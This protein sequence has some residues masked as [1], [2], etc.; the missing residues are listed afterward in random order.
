MLWAAGLHSGQYTRPVNYDAAFSPISLRSLRKFGRPFG[1]LQ[2]EALSFLCCDGI[3]V[4]QPGI[5]PRGHK[6]GSDRDR[7][8]KQQ[9]LFCSVCDFG[10]AKHGR[11]SALS[12]AFLGKCSQAWEASWAA[13]QSEVSLQ[14]WVQADWMLEASATSVWRWD[15]EPNTSQSVVQALQSRTGNDQRQPKKWQT[16]ISENQRQRPSDPEFG[17][18]RQQKEHLRIGHDI[19]VI[20]GH[21]VDNCQKGLAPEKKCKDGATP[22][23][24]WTE[25]FPSTDLRDQ[26]GLDE[27]GSSRIPQQSG[28]NRWD[29]DCHFWARNQTPVCCVDPAKWRSSSEGPETK[30]TKENNDDR[31]LRLP[32]CHLRQVHAPRRHNSLGG[33][34][35]N[36]G[37]V[38][39]I[40]QEE[41]TSSL[42]PQ[43]WWKLLLPP[44]SGQCSV[45]CGSA[46]NCQI[47]R[48]GNRTV[49]T[50]T[51]LSG[52][53]SVWFCS[54]PEAQG[55]PQGTSLC[56]PWTAEGWGQKIAQILPRWV[57][58]AS[59]CR[60]G[61]KVEEVHCDG[62]W[63]LRRDTC[64]STP[65]GLGRLIGQFT[66]GMNRHL[67]HLRKITPK[68]FAK[69]LCDGPFHVGFIA[70]L[71]S[72]VGMLFD[73]YDGMLLFCWH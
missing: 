45:P 68:P 6:I 18:S 8:A 49:G 33:L 61:H 31:V 60:H 48:V 67:F 34:L 54:F 35:W 27:T 55:R 56:Q 21:C 52:F 42:D 53:G 72:I 46:N 12:L 26:P 5:D 25:G 40:S 38:Q 69:C 39:G 24:R 32:G 29:M 36:I 19:R 43:S 70:I 3:S 57:L 59:L 4:T 20:Q 22:P 65:W 37:K 58:W 73:F 51:V 15:N 7:S 66:R 1:T 64:C 28:H 9:C 62:R 30:G 16:T 63:L 10:W 71:N 47:Q 14:S 11:V 23:D 50:P 2:V 41:E 44:S 17:V 13:C